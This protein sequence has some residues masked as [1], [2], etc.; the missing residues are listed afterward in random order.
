MTEKCPICGNEIIK[1]GM[2]TCSDFCRIQYEAYKKWCDECI[3][4]D[5]LKYIPR[6][7][8]EL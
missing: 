7:E 4:E 1:D 2:E 3:M 6:Y 8:D 5:H